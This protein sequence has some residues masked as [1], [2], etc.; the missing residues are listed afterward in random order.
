[1]LGINFNPR[2]FNSVSRINL[3]KNYSRTGPVPKLLGVLVVVES[4]LT[5]DNPR[6]FNTLALRVV[7]FCKADRDQWV[8]QN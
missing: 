8:Y 1:M 2:P 4:I 7:G 5:R 3:T 6:Y